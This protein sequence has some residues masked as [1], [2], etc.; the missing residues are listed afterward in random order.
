MLR[1]SREWAESKAAT[2][3]LEILVKAVA[4]KEVRG[5]RRAASLQ[6]G[7][8]RSARS[9]WKATGRENF[10]LIKRHRKGRAHL[11]RARD[12]SPLAG[13]EP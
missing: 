11:F 5:D 1:V 13:A 8:R 7:T 2:E 4:R 10:N 12:L 9:P 6:L 3:E